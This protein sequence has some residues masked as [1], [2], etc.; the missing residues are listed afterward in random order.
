MSTSITQ[1]SDSE[2]HN[3]HHGSLQATLLSLPVDILLLILEHLTPS[4]QLHLASVN[5]ALRALIIP[6]YLPCESKYRNRF[7]R[8][9]EFRLLVQEE[10]RQRVE[11]LNRIVYRDESG[12]DT[13][14]IRGG[15]APSIKLAC[16]RCLQLL[17]F[18]HF[19]VEEADK[20]KNGS[21]RSRR[22][23][24]C[25][26]CR[27]RLSS[28]TTVNKR[29]RSGW[30]PTSYGGRGIWGD[31]TA[32]ISVRTFFSEELFTACVFCCGL[33][34][35]RMDKPCQ[36][37]YIWK[38][39]TSLPGQHYCKEGQSM[40]DAEDW[41]ETTWFRLD[42]VLG[43]NPSRQWCLDHYSKPQICNPRENGKG[44]FCGSCRTF[45]AA[46][47]ESL[48]GKPVLLKERHI[49]EP[50]KGKGALCTDQRCCLGRF[51]ECSTVNR[52]G[53]E[54]PANV[55]LEWL[56]EYVERRL[57]LGKTEVQP[58][59]R[60]DGTFIP[61]MFYT[62]GLDGSCNTGTDNEAMVYLT[63]LELACYC[64]DGFLFEPE[65]YW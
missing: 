5:H 63:N 47:H 64:Q 17:P 60:R 49:K 54:S 37:F 13:A 38:G 11:L 32:G 15:P 62:R 25:I 40:L 26:K 53:V 36:S 21:R 10:Q 24:Q 9:Q 27:I 31:S 8:R 65:E 16:S 50:R 20:P 1:S 51:Q 42:P 39:Q 55:S 46:A 23:R 56:I 14:Y 43:Y 58:Y 59:M 3:I 33:F 41:E 52:G 22:L 18:Y 35:Q 19:A 45:A 12:E 57:T 4:N 29:Q 34:R 7:V 48:A 44:I 30:T 6:R 61:A 2:S 28:F